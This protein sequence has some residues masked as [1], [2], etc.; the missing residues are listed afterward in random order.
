MKNATGG[1]SSL[2]D[3]DFLYYLYFP[4]RSPMRTTDCFKLRELGDDHLLVGPSDDGGRRIVRLN[5]AAAFL[6]RSVAGSEFSVADLSALLRNEYGLDRE[7]A[8]S[9]AGRIADAWL[10]SYLLLP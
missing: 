5:A 4:E 6:W 10:A 3:A 8:D 2:C 7:R 9:D 1:S